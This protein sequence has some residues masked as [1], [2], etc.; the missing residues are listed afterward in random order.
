MHN[1]DDWSCFTHYN[2]IWQDSL[3]HLVQ[4]HQGTARTHGIP[5]GQVIAIHPGLKLILYVL[6]LLLRMKNIHIH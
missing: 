5:L 6:T 1:E 4:Q 2:K 3:T